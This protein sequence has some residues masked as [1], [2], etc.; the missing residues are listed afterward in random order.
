MNKTDEDLIVINL[1]LN[2]RKIKQQ[3]YKP[4]HLHTLIPLKGKTQNVRMIDEIPS[5]GHLHMCDDLT[6]T[7]MHK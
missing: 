4:I 6:Q 2:E 3:L 1:Q 5:K 7:H